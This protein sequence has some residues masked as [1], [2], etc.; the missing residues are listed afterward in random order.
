[1]GRSQSAPSNGPP[2]LSLAFPPPP[3]L[4]LFAGLVGAAVAAE[5]VR[6]GGKERKSEERPKALPLPR[7]PLPRSPVTFSTE[8]KM[9]AASAATLPSC[10]PT[11]PCLT[12]EALSQSGPR[13]GEAGHTSAGQSNTTLYNVYRGRLKAE[14]FSGL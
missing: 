6:H 10:R 12:E 9:A 14:A 11:L 8:Q 7:R 5:C 13:N 3:H 2:R 1:M 4:F